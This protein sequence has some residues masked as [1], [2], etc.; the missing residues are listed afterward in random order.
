MV[1]FQTLPKLDYGSDFLV[2]KSEHLLLRKDLY[3][4][5]SKPFTM[6]DPWNP[7]WTLLPLWAQYVAIDAYSIHPVMFSIEPHFDESKGKYYQAI[8][9][10]KLISKSALYC[11]GRRLVK[12]NPLS[13][14]RIFKL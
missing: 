1:D 2:T 5:F 14:P 8:G 10:R 12:V 7:N 4:R 13:V 11:E 9:S 6:Y 3:E